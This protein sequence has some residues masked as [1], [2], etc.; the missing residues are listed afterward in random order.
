MTRVRTIAAKLDARSRTVLRRFVFLLSYF[1][2]LTAIFGARYPL[3]MFLV[4]TSVAA[5]VEI[6]MALLRREKMAESSLG[7]WDLAAAFIGLHCLARG[8]A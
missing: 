7:S 1:L 5:T 4:M 6:G 3:P 8:L 2:F